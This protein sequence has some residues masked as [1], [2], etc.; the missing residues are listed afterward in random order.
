MR[1]HSGLFAGL[2]VAALGFSAPAHAITVSVLPF[3]ADAVPGTTLTLELSISG[4][5]AQAAPSLGAFDIDIGF[6]P[7]LLTVTG[8]VPGDGLGSVDAL[9]AIDVGFGLTAPGNFNVGV[10]SILGEGTLNAIQPTAFVLAT[11][12][13]LVGSIGIGET[14]VVGFGT[15]AA[16]S[17]GFG[18]PLAIDVLTA[19]TLTGAPI[20]LPAPLGLFLVA[21]AALAVFRR[22]EQ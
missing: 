17:D 22:R 1:H 11:V 2:L 18:D 8:Y 21:L 13:F 4:L 16:L 5:G 19:S 20:P 7:A 14:T 10:V 12:E 3:A 6:D 15:S 9:E